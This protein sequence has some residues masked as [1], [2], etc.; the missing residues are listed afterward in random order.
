MNNDDEYRTKLAPIE[1]TL[2]NLEIFKQNPK[3]LLRLKMNLEQESFYEAHQLFKTIHFRA[4]SI[5]LLD[6]CLHLIYYGIIYFETKSQL[7][8]TF[9]LAKVFIDT[10]K[11]STR[12]TA[13]DATLLDQLKR[14]HRALRSGAEERN[15]FSVAALKWSSSLFDSRTVEKLPPNFNL[16][17]RPTIVDDSSVVVARLVAE[18]YSTIY[19]KKFGHFQLHTQFALNYWHEKQYGMARY[20]FLHSLDG[21]LF[22]R[23]VVENHETHGFP[24]EIDLFLVQAVLQYLCLRNLE[25]A[26]Q[27]FYS[28]LQNH[29]KLDDTKKKRSEDDATTSTKATTSD[30]VRPE[31]VISAARHD[32]SS[33]YLN[34]YYEEYPLI[35]FINFLFYAIRL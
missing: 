12:I 17:Y 4:S 18:N 32:D 1:S 26:H 20:H 35:N 29:P 9:D 5:D 11:K 25:C 7:Y 8:C 21:S 10:L 22:A 23:M 30:Q 24:S 27:F 33:F 15:E 14:I 19:Q 3:F 31:H 2:A 28:Y 34:H 6:D 13:I 16:V